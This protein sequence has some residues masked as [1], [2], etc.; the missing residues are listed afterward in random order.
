MIVFPM[1]RIQ[2]SAI[3]A[4]SRDSQQVTSIMAS[5]LTSSKMV[6]LVLAPEPNKEYGQSKTREKIK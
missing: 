6:V 4:S 5:R 3:N 2:P 1:E